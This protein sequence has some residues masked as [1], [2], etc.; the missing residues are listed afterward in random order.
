MT[1]FTSLIS[2]IIPLNRKDIDTD[3]IIPADYLK[4][5]SSGG[6]GEHLFQRLR[7]GE[8]DFALNNPLFKDSQV[9]VAQDNF[10]CGSSREHAVWSLLEY[11][12]KAIIAPSFADIFFSNSGKNGLLT[13]IL[14]EE[15]IQNILQASESRTQQNKTFPISIDLES[16]SLEITDIGKFSFP[17]DPFRKDC[18]LNGHDDLDYLLEHTNEI[19]TWKEEREKEIFYKTDTAN[20]AN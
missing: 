15:D 14:P 20:F 6:Y 9:I 7:D 1:P 4:S 11:G 10:G 17:Y 18:I 3:M 8:P 12:I 16:Q 5:V 2:T 13:I 19:N